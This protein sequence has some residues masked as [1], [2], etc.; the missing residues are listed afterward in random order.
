MEEWRDIPEYEDIYQV[1]DQGTVRRVKSGRLLRPR[2]DNGYL[3]VSLCVSGK[4]RNRYIHRLVLSAFVSNPPIP[5]AHGNHINGDTHDNRLD[6]LQWC[7]PTENAIHAR[8]RLQRFAGEHNSN[9]KLSER[10]AKMV[11]YLGKMGLSAKE[12]AHQFDM[13]VEGVRMILTGRTW[14]H[15]QGG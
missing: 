3:S 1:S 14:K 15:L 2:N 11:I 7:S 9:A 12:I 10:E 4:K 8:D 13:S 6:N 5:H